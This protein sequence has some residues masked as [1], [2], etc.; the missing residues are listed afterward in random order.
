MKKVKI[1][2]FI[3]ALLL[4]FSITAMPKSSNTSEVSVDAI[5]GNYTLNPTEFH[6]ANY[7]SYRLNRPINKTIDTFEA[8]IFVSPNSTGGVLMSNYTGDDINFSGKYVEYSIDV[9]GRVKVNWGGKNVIT[10]N[11]G[12]VADG[13]WHHIAVIRNRDARTFT[14]YIDGK[15][16][17]VAS[18][19]SVCDAISERPLSFGVDVIA[20]GNTKKRP[21]DK[22]KIEQVT[23]YNGAISASRVLEDMNNTSITSND[24][25][26]TLLTNLYFGQTW[27]KRTVVDTSGQNLNAQLSSYDK[28]V[29]FVPPTNYDYSLLVIPDIQTTVNYK[30]KLRPT[31]SAQG[32]A[33]PY[34]GVNPPATYDT[35]DT[36]EMAKWINWLKST[37]SKYNTKFA[38]QVGDLSDWGQHETF[39]KWGAYYMNQ[40]NGVLP[41]SF[42]QGNH[43]YDLN[44][45]AQDA[46]YSTYFNASFP[47]STHS[48][49]PGFGAAMDGATMSNTYYKY[50][51]NGIKYLVI[52][53]ECGPRL[54][55][56]RWAGRLCEQFADHR[57]I[58]NTH[59]YM[60]DDA[61]L[62]HTGEHYS[63]DTYAWYQAT[64]ANSGQFMFDQLVRKYENIFMVVCGHITCEDILM[65]TDVGDH[66]NKI[67]SLLVDFQTAGY[68]GSGTGSE[69]TCIMFFNEE[70]KTIN[71]AYYSAVFDAVHNVHNQ[72][73]ISFAD[74]NNPTI[75]A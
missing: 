19:S 47:Y 31:A 58:L 25:N 74:A 27:T 68:R 64:E 40:L 56:L 1:L 14:L 57:V 41:Y 75:G 66:G 43:D 7:Y 52:N 29:K 73:Q 13:K 62:L 48:K 9:T 22:G 24:T 37:P 34:A 17:T 3:I 11:K 63:M 30:S 50:D 59:A 8:R 65:R 33:F 54:E 28:I 4:V 35:S 60:E 26:A 72:F 38:M 46:R 39:Y 67:T 42:V 20:D 16:N 61:S 12:F 53:L 44:C 71:F 55:V 45:N 6:I 32:V 23:L 2:S 21:L 69:A 5:S 49:L 51:V 36:S 10:F 70:Q 18:F 15:V